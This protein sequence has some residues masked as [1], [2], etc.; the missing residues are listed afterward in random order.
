[1][2]NSYT[3]YFIKDQSET[4]NNVYIIANKK[5]RKA[6]VVD[7]GCSMAQIKEMVMLYNLELEKVLITHSH[8]DH[9]RCVS[10]L[11]DTFKCEIYISKMEAEYYLFSCQNMK[12][13]E[14]EDEIFIGDTKIKCIL[15]PGHTYGSV[16]YL[17]EN[18]IFTGDTIF[19]EGCGLCVGDGASVDKMYESISKIK[20]Y[21]ADDVMVYPGHTYLNEPGKSIKFLKQNNI[22]FCLDKQ[23]FIKFRMR[24]KQTN[25]Y[26]FS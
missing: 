5:T 8:K 2:E 15:T 25:L 7:P 22:Y 6:A 21:M 11:A 18:K 13:I 4:K 17:A 3:L 23:D 10:E 1:M 14:N 16:C 9:T 19:I 26:D 12:M 24:S 20:Y